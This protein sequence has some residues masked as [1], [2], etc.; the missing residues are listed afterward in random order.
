MSPNQTEPQAATFQQRLRS[1]PLAT[2]IV[3]CLA[4]VVLLAAAVFTSRPRTSTKLISLLGETRL[5]TLDIQRIRMAL[6]QAGIV[7]AEVRDQQVW[8]PR[9]RVATALKVINEQNVLP[10]GLKAESPA[11]PNISPFASRLQQQLQ[12]QHQKKVAIQSLV[13]RL[14]FVA[15]AMLEIDFGSEATQRST[16]PLRCTL[17]IQPSDGSY[18]ETSQLETIRQIAIGSLSQLQPE[19]L[20]IVD[21]AAGI[22]FDD[23][24]LEKPQTTE[25]VV[26]IE[27]LRY[28][29]RLDREIQQRLADIEGVEISVSCRVDSN[30]TLDFAPASVVAVKRSGAT[31][32]LASG[33]ISLPG[34]NGTASVEI[35]TG[36]QNQ[37]EIGNS[38]VSSQSKVP[39]FLPQVTIRLPRQLSASSDQPAVSLARSM[40]QDQ[41]RKTVLERVR[42]LLPDSAFNTPDQFPITVEFAAAEVAAQSNPGTP[43]AINQWLSSRSG[44]IWIAVIST[45]GLSMLLLFSL[46]RRETAGDVATG[47]SAYRPNEEAREIKLK[48]Q[49]DELL[50]SDPDTAAN[51]IRDWIQKAA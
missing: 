33:P 29:Q 25:Q 19:N 8:L 51:V 44:G 1:L 7:D 18:L 41:L 20:V 14:P 27:K 35:P 4:I 3:G 43:M 21:L 47:E 24:L 23:K 17:T 48:Q 26:E 10:A 30:Q 42:P 11:A 37:R 46:R 31:A 2:R 40:E 9:E 39:A 16:G 13:R 12:Q 28:R 36:N 6:S 50:R 15:D 49:I 34:T 32:M 5:Q 45:A 22:A 38:P